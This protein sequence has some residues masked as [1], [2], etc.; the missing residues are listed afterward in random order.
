MSLIDKVKDLENIQKEI[1]SVVEDVDELLKD[2]NLLS[3]RSVIGTVTIK[4]MLDAEKF[5]RRSLCELNDKVN[6]IILTE[7][8]LKSINIFNDVLMLI[9]ADSEKINVTAISDDQTKTYEYGLDEAH[10]IM[11]YMDKLYPRKEI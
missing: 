11:D 1:G 9:H 5:M 3:V 10:M 2:G 8:N 6:N 7:A 4:D